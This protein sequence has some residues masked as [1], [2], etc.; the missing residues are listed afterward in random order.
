M[1]TALGSIASTPSDSLPGALPGGPIEQRT[2]EAL[3]AG[4][5]RVLE[6]VALGQALPVVLD[7]LCRLVEEISDDSF[8]SIL[9]IDSALTTFHLGAAPSLPAGYNEAMD[10]RPARCDGGPCGMAA[11]LK[12]Q[13]IVPDIAADSRWD[14]HGWRALALGYGLRACWSSPILSR[15]GTVLGTFAIYQREPRDPSPIH[16]RL[17][18]QLTHIASIAIERARSDAALKRSE[19]F[20]AEAQALSRTGSFSWCLATGEINWSE[21]VYRIFELEPGEIVTFPLIASRVHPDDM[22]MLDEMINGEHGDEMEFE[23]RLIFS[24]QSVK[25]LHLIARKITNGE[26]RLEY[27]GAVQDVTDR[28]L[29][30][31][32]LGKARSELAHVARVTSLGVMT[33][34]IAHE[35]SQPLSGIIT[36][37][38]TC[39]RM[40]AAEPPNV[41]GARETVQRTLRDGNRATEVITRLRSLFSRKETSIE[42]LDLNEAV[43]EVLALTAGELQRNGAVLRSELAEG[44]PPIAGDRVQLQQVMLNLLLNASDAMGTVA[45]RPRQLVISTK[46][47]ADRQVSFVVRDAGVGFQ[48]HTAD[49]L[50]DAFYTTKTRG[51]GIGLSISR[52][53]IETHHGRLWGVP[54]EDGPGATFSFSVPHDPGPHS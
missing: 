54:N 48:P 1:N 8:C 6:M 47:E 20:L 23:H 33:A 25:Y 9:D 17:I 38:S 12:T 21:Q 34:S 29:S 22:Y 19:T 28:R 4:E 37:A 52:S 26:G 2:T 39:L 50:F 11:H 51:M 7:A 14:A 41:D 35:V 46:A 13:V 10:G 15:E 36:N 18:G 40:L 30:E 3:L 5:K 53:I 16:L 49:K 43:R 42:S 27:I 24:D 32:A 44:L 31:E 45:D